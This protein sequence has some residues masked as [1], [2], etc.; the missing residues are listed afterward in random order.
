MSSVKFMLT[1]KMANGETLQW[2]HKYDD[3]KAIVSCGS[4]KYTQP[5]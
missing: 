1:L 5:F 3:E 4:V 2:C